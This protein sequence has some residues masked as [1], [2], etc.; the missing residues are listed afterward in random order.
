M[1]DQNGVQRITITPKSTPKSHAAKLL[2]KIY[3]NVFAKFEISFIDVS[4]DFKE[5]I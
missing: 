1:L 5:K 3:Q 4:V 2:L